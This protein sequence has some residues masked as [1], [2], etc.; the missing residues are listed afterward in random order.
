MTMLY[1]VKKKKIPFCPLKTSR[2]KKMKNN[3]LKKYFPRTFT[4]ASNSNLFTMLFTQLYTKHSI[5]VGFILFMI[6]NTM[7][8]T[9]N[10]SILILLNSKN[11]IDC[12]CCI[13]FIRS[14]GPKAPLLIKGGYAALD[15]VNK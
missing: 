2:K 4:P 5:Y 13:K 1:C 10:E 15:L 8:P 7:F 11:L 6:S 14:R 12:G 9:I 3:Y